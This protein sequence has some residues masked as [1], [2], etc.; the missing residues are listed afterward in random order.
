MSQKGDGSE[1][2]PSVDGVILLHGLTGQGIEAANIGGYIVYIG[3][4]L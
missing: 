1:R 3:L 2:E 4:T